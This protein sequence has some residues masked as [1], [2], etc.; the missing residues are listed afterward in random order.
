MDFLV[1]TN[2]CEMSS[3]GIVINGIEGSHMYPHSLL[4]PLF[5]S[6]NSN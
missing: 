1:A 6:E 5:E 3:C 2:N 4:Q